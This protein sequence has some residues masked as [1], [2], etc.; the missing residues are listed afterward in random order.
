MS[1]ERIGYDPKQVV[2]KTKMP[3]FAKKLHSKWS[4]RKI[5]TSTRNNILPKIQQ[6]KYIAS[7]MHQHC[8]GHFKHNN[9]QNIDCPEEL[10]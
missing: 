2:H 5:L 7:N 10:R 1:E 6:N 9:D 3:K 8:S 4:Y